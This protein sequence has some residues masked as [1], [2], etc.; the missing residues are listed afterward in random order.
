MLMKNTYFCFVHVLHES[1]CTISRAHIKLCFHTQTH[2][3]HTQKSNVV[4]P[5]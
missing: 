2:T 1:V 5:V 3:L 4:E